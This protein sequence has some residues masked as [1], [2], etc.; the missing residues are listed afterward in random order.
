MLILNIEKRDI[1]TNLKEIREGGN[2][3]A[4]F[5]GREVESTPITVSSSEFKSVWKKTGSSALISLKGLKGEREAVIQDMDIDPITSQVRHIDF[6]I[7]ERGK[8]M[9]A[10][11]PFVFVGESPAIKGLG[12]ILI[13]VMYELKIE[14]FPKDLP[15]NIEVD[16]SSLTELDSQIA[17]KDLKLSKE[18]KVLDDVEEVVAAVTQASE[19]PEE[20]ESVDISE[21]KIEKKGKKEEPAEES[22]DKPEE[23]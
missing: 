1:K 10:T 9:E 21:V 15:Q 8:L 20:T 4:V 11:V 12:G 6:Y 22:S 16:I 13:K 2:I 17:V 18:I 14:V 3:P 23:K 19:E 5:Y 7:I